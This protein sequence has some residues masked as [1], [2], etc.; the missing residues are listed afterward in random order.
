[1]DRI[2]VAI[3][4]KK[5][6]QGR[7]DAQKA[8]EQGAQMIEF[9]VDYC[10]K[11]QKWEI[12]HF[13][14]LTQGFSC[15]II[16]TMRRSSE[17]GQS[18]IEEEARYKI[19]EKMFYIHPQFIDIE[20]ATEL[21]FKQRCAELAAQFQV[22][23]IYSYH[24]FKNTPNVEGIK[25]LFSKLLSKCPSAENT[26]TNPEK[27]HLIKLIFYANSIEDNLSPLFLCQFAA[28]KNI[29]IISFAMGEFGIISRIFALKYGS[30][31]SFA[32][33]RDTTA[34]GQV[35]MDDFNNL[36]QKDGKIWQ[37]YSIS[38]ENVQ[39]ILQNLEKKK[40]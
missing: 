6:E 36:M 23:L 9:R 4:V 27:Q 15:P 17:G 16:V 8:V 25:E 11:I 22:R 21:S 2:C 34:P 14:R 20:I 7:E 24:D 33:L 26:S 31:L 30:Y 40:L 5:I 32:S 39:K 18:N 3:P 37:K 12:S 10:P 35:P 19:I 13:Q 28:S 38:L 29:P 1:M